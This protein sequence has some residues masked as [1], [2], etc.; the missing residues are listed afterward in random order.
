MRTREV[1]EG[2]EIVGG[3]RG[4]F[5]ENQ[6]KMGGR[7]RRRERR[8]EIEREKERM[9]QREREEKEKERERDK[10]PLI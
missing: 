1:W 2:R 4:I 7:K 6:R 5:K 8:R 10:N 9:R 3:E